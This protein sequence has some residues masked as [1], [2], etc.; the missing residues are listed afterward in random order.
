MVPAVNALGAVNFAAMLII[1]TALFKLV[2][3]RFPDSAF[4]K[5]LAFLFF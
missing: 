1:I 4:G 3:M 5:A 2:A